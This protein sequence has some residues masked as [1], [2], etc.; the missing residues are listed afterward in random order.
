MGRIREEGVKTE[1]GQSKGEG[2]GESVHRFREKDQVRVV[3][4]N[5]VSQSSFSKEVGDSPTV[6]IED[7]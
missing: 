7:L 2:G 1:A 4:A 3:T 6:P 5:Q